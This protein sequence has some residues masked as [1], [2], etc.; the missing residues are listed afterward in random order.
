MTPGRK[1]L[2]QVCLTA[3]LV[4]LAGQWIADS[5]RIKYWPRDDW[6]EAINVYAYQ[7]SR[8]RADILFLGSSLTR[9]GIVP[10]TLRRQ[11]KDAAIEA[12]VFNLGRRSANSLHA[13]VIL[14][15]MIGSNGCPEMIVLEVSARSLNAN[16]DQTDFISDYASF[17]DLPI[18]APELLSLA[19]AD[20]FLSSRLRGLLALYYRAAELRKDWQEELTQA[21]RRA[22]GSWNPRRPDRR[23]RNDGRRQRFE[24]VRRHAIDRL[25]EHVEIGGA[26]SR[27]LESVA[28][29]AADCESRLLLLR[30][31]T[32]LPLDA[33]EQIPV[34]SPFEDYIRAFSRR[35]SIALYEIDPIDVGL[36]YE[37]YID[38]VHLNW[39][40]ATRFT[41]FLAE[42]V[43]GPELRAA[44]AAHP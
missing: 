33:K 2:L 37:H 28:R 3:A 38:F 20:A 36:D 39:T 17:R 42:E 14:R 41:T 10:Q 4:A 43:I 9:S 6:S 18:M 40:G 13:A 26:G 29:L 24:R 31:P 19:G 27:G 32:I 1:K 22:G 25:L 30:L 12:S 23:E 35:S 34:E 11:L 44:R 7:Q 16:N 21:L 15:D 5:M 8:L